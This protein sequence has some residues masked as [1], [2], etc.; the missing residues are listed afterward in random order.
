M[1]QQNKKEVVPFE[2]LLGRLGVARR[3]L[4]W[5]GM[6]SPR[7]NESHRDCNSRTHE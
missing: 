6:D 4:D 7:S 5:I 1:F 2:I 3:E